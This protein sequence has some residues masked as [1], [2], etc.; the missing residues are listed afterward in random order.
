[1]NRRQLV[2][3]L[4][5]AP[6]GTWLAKSRPAFAGTDFEPLEKTEAEWRAL[7]EEP[8][9]RVLFK[10]D[11]ERPFSSPLNDEKR[12]GVFIC[13]ACYLPLFGKHL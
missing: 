11:T 13:A 6:A 10:E 12:D 5:L 3:I 7:L 9:F 1:M 2:S 4:T 8:R